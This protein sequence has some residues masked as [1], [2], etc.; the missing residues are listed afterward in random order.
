MIYSF[1]HPFIFISQTEQKGRGVYC[2]QNIEANT[3][4]EIA[5]V[6]P[7]SEK[8]TKII[9]ETALH[10]Y[11]FSWGDDQK[12]SAVA[13]GY[14]SMYNHAKTPN[15]SYEADFENNTI[16]IISLKEIPKGEELTINYNLDFNSD[17]KLWFEIK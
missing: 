11:Y 8:D 17:N 6:V 10:D 9:H 16:K 14:V 4:I 13:L 2:H 3:L 15:C 5:P 12:L 7:L 1:V